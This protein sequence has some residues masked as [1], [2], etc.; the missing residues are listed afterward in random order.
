MNVVVD[1]AVSF[2]LV[3][4]TPLYSSDFTGRHA[5]V[6]VIGGAGA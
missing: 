6:G 5:A 4:V 1:A 3:S 2:E